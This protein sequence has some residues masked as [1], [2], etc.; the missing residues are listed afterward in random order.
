MF[1]SLQEAADRIDKATPDHLAVPKRFFPLPREFVSPSLPAAFGDCP[2]AVE[3]ARQFEPMK[4]WINGAFGKIEFAGASAAYL[5]NDSVAVG[6]SGRQSGHNDHLK[7]TF[8]NF[9]FHATSLRLS[10]AT[11]GFIRS[12]VNRST[13]LFERH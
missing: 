10:L 6:R 11:L 2:T 3:Q 9:T 1:D 5:L 8:E 12:F 4:D 7:V 13:E